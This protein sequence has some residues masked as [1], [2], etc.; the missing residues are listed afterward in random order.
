MRLALWKASY[1]LW[2]LLSRRWVPWRLR[3]RA[4]GRLTVASAAWTLGSDP[5]YEWR[6]LGVELRA[7]PA[8][9]TVGGRRRAVSCVEGLVVF[10]QLDSMYGHH[11]R[12]TFRRDCDGMLWYVEFDETFGRVPVSDVVGCFAL[13]RAVYGGDFEQK[14]GA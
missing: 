7:I 6:H 9:V 13:V 14:G 10:S 8:V 2:W 5:V 11:S 1:P 4:V 3:S 12:I